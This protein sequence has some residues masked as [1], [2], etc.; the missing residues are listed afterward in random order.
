M[1][2]SFPSSLQPFVSKLESR[3]VL[4]DEERR[5][6]LDLPFHPRHVQANEDFVQQG[7]EV[8]H[9]CFILEGMVG[10]FGQTKRGERQITSVFLGGDMIDLNTVVVPQ[11]IADLQALIPSTILQVPHSALRS[12]AGQYP[13]IAE[14]F[15]RECVIDAAVLNEWVMNVG[16][17]DA[18]ARL[19]HLLC[20]IACRSGGTGIQN[21]Y[22][23]P[24]PIT[25]NQLADM[26]GL[27]AVH[28]N[29]TLKGLR[30]DR[31]VD[32]RHR[33]VL[34]TNWDRLVQ[35]GEFNSDYLRLGNGDGACAGRV[36]VPERR[37]Q[38]VQ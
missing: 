22:S 21:G 14:A 10:T 35:I 16:R 30:E 17:R 23:F 5:V 19:A 38:M 28:V 33:M 20:E 6:I 25:Q 8:T 15:W 2:A 13:G 3:S 4:T 7:Q 1:R 26:L 31:I 9:S 37:M 32:I 27:T 24:F 36:R 12:A 29:R 18:R 34:V 11:A